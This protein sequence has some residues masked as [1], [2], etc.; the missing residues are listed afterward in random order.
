MW[1]LFAVISI[2]VA[3]VTIDCYTKARNCSILPE[4]YKGNDERHKHVNKRRIYLI[5]TFFVKYVF[6]FKFVSEC[7][8]VNMDT[9]WK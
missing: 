3:Y 4:Y 7:G 9:S 6:A 2:D 1:L 8:C 5:Y